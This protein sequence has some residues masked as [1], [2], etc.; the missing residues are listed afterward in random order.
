[1]PV[2]LLEA[3]QRRVCVVGRLLGADQVVWEFD[4][5]DG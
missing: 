3:E 2:L 5:H 4:G 1:V